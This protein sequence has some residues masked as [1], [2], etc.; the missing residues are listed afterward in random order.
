[1]SLEPNT[2]ISH[3]KILSEIG[4]GGMGIVYLAQDTKLDRKV[5]IKFLP[6]D[7]SQDKEKLQRFV[8]EAKAASALNHPGIL[9]IYEIGEAEGSTYI[10]SEYI[11]G[12]DVGTFARERKI[13]LEKALDIAI[14]IVTALKAAHDSGIV[15]RDIKPDNVMIREDGIIKILDFGLAKLLEKRSGGEKAVKTGP[16]SETMIADAGKGPSTTPGMVMGTVNYMSPEQARGRDVDQ[17]TDIFSVGALLYEVLTR[18]RAFDGDNTSDAIAAVLMKDPVPITELNPEIPNRL[19]EIV[20]KCL[21]K[22]K[23]ERFESSKELLDELTRLKRHLQIEEI[24]KTILPEEEHKETKMF[25]ATTADAAGKTTGARTGDGDSIIIRKSVAGKIAAAVLALLIAGVAG[26]FVWRYA[27]GGDQ[28]IDSIAVMPFVNESGDAEL[29]YLSDGMT[30]TLIN[31]LSK[32]P[33]L[34]VKSRSSV[35]AYKGKTFNA[36]EIAGQLNVQSILNGRV[37]KR[38]DQILLSL[39]LID[40]RTD[41]VLWGN[42]YSRSASELV[43]LQSEIAKDVSANLKSRLSA[44]SEQE[45]TKTYTNS[46]EAYRNYL[47]GRYYWNKRTREDLAKSVEYFNKAIELDPAYALAYSGL[48]QSYVLFPNYGVAK[49]KESMPRA[50]A[51]ADR[52]LEIDNS[53]AEAHAALGLYYSSYAWNTDRS[54]ESLRRALELDPDYETAYHW[55]GQGPLQATGRFDESIA[56]GDRAA[57]LD[58]LS[59]VIK[60]DSGYNRISARRFDEG[61]EVINAALEMDPNFPYAWSAL[62]EGYL[63]K[64]DLDKAIESLQRSLKLEDSAYVKAVLARALAKKGDRTSAFEILDELKIRSRNEYVRSLCFVLVYSSLG[65]LDA[66]FEWIERMFEERAL[67]MMY[68]DDPLLDDLKDDPRFD[69]L[70]GRVRDAKLH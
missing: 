12:I 48:A 63:G 27:F 2:L 58:P 47:Q 15:H 64:G 4:K 57:E 68:L 14:Q 50:K 21:Q 70:Q 34:S 38:G 6:S 60:T 49:P 40:P 22:D 67:F 31:S 51:A 13:S 39:E 52:A 35:F 3:Y 53:L 20:E 45:V 44:P 1:M 16:D 11:G 24:E 7:S 42:S 62:G 18:K 56:A 61:I 5:A 25:P 30:E 41:S 19:Q 55:L 23:K 32:I 9:T 65:D 28:R 36:A 37:A 10:A 54:E 17:R 69:K 33:D 29:E 46:P 66:S 26:Y 8:Q 59:L 43:S